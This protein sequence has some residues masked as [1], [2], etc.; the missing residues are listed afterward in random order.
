[1]NNKHKTQYK[2]YVNGIRYVSVD[3][4]KNGVTVKTLDYPKSD[5]LDS[6]RFLGEI[7]PKTKL[8]NV[9][10]ELLEQEAIECTK[11]NIDYVW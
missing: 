9:P 11:F 3:I 7:D 5:L 2:A 8:A 1:M 6:M 10:N 4:I